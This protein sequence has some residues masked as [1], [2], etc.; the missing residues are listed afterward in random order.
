MFADGHNAGGTGIRDLQM[1]S[2]RRSGRREARRG[3]GY[4]SD[5]NGRRRNAGR[6]T[7][8]TPDISPGPPSK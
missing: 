6:R 7:S 1:G 4:A 2:G 8:T 5:G 3:L